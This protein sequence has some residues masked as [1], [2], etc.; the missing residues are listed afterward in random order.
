[1]I[2]QAVLQSARLLG[3]VAR[4]FAGNMVDKL[5]P[6]LPRIA[7]NLAKSLMLV[8]ALNPRIGYDK[9]V[10]IAKLALQDDITLKEAA[11]RLGHVAPEDFDRWVR[12]EEM[13][14]PG[15]TLDGGG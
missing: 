2:I 7:D 3:D 1:V 6:N 15:T 12:P 11:A 5:E 10:A 8:T 4:S 14:H 13:V 9:A